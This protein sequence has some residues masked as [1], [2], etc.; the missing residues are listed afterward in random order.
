[1][2]RLTRHCLQ[3]IVLATDLDI[4]KTNWGAAQSTGSRSIFVWD[5]SADGS[6]WS[7][8]RLV[9]LMPP[10]AGYVSPSSQNQPTNQFPSNTNNQTG[11]GALRNLGRP[12]NLLRRLL[13]LRRLRR[14]R[15]S[16][17]RPIHRAVYLLL[18]HQR[19]RNF[20]LAPALESRQH[21]QS[22]IRKSSTSAEHLTSA[23]SAIPTR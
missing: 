16:A 15:H 8:E 14:S 10:T 13:V 11:L 18:A 22:S 2:T 17:Y 9:E 3:Y 20:H 7:R 5:S 21:G 19:F 12:N 23:T 1:M 4:S 6:T